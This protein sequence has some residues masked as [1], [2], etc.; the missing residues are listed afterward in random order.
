M[1]LLRVKAKID[2]KRKIGVILPLSLKIEVKMGAI[3]LM[4][5][6]FKSANCWAQKLGGLNIFDNL[7]IF[8]SFNVLDG[9]NISTV[10]E[11]LVILR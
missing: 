3:V 11:N 5:I 10:L 2:N 6:E 7:Y 8:N 4:T 9:L 1:A